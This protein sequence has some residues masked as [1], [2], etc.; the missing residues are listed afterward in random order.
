MSTALQPGVPATLAGRIDP[1]ILIDDTHGH[2]LRWRPGERL[3]QLFE[4]VCDRLRADGATDRLCVD[5]PGAAL[6]YGEVDARANRL[7][8]YLLSRGIGPGHRVALLFDDPAQAYVAL[9]AVLKAGA[10]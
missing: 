9:L 4:Q 8:R 7:A 1:R 10:A 5:A 2:H 3:E 6:T